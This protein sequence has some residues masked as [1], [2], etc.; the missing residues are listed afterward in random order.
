MNQAPANSDFTVCLKTAKRIFAMKWLKR[1]AQGFSPGS[2]ICEFGK[3]SRTD[4]AKVAWHEVPGKVVLRPRRR[5]CGGGLLSCNLDGTMRL[6]GPFKISKLQ[7]HGFAQRSTSGS[8]LAYVLVLVVIAGLIC[9]SYLAFVNN[10]AAI[11][12]RNLN[13]D[14]L[15]ISTEQALLSLESAI[16]NELLATGEVRLASLNRSD[17]VSGISLRVGSKLDGEGTDVLQ[18]QPFAN[19]TQLGEL[20]TLRGQDLFDQ[21]QARVT[22]IDVDITTLST[23]P[24]VRL[25]NLRLTDHPKIAVREIPVSQFTVFSAGDPCTLGTTVFSQDIGR[26]FSIS[27]LSITG[28]FST[29]FTI[30][31]GQNVD[32]NGGSIQVNDPS[33]NGPSVKLA[34]STGE[35]DFLPEARTSLDSRIIT[36]S[37]IPVDS[38][39]L[40]SVYANGNNGTASNATSPANELNLS[41]LKSQCDLLV[42]ARP[43]ITITTP[44]G[45]REC[46]VTVVGNRGGG[47]NLTYPVGTNKA[48][49]GSQGTANLQTV[50]FAA[51]QNSQNSSQTILALDYARLGAAQLS[52]VYLVVQDPGGNPLPNAVVLIRGAQA[53]TGPVSIVSPHPIIIAGDFNDGN[54]SPAASIITPANVQTVAA[55]WGSDVLGNF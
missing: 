42:V 19:S 12:A 32:F 25:P 18:V 41:L 39:A 44:S 31:A 34:S 20:S 10:Q 50:P 3:A 38:A 47:A 13:Q 53:L 23:G 11:T 37:V 49:S 29:Q 43:D 40:N 6:Q 5:L 35:T 30:V 15:R 21:A 2:G 45:Q 8:V 16:R 24:N 14:G 28:D 48:C 9:A 26:I 46:L 1:L 54:D 33:G 52:S 55:N 27:T 17:A 4:Y 36:S 51:A 7:A 22:Y